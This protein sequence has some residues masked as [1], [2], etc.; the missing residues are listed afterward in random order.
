MPALSSGAASP[1]R[2]VAIGGL[3]A[4]AIDITYAAGFWY[5]RSGVPPTRIFQSVAA[6]LLG[7][8][9]AVAGGAPTAALGLALHFLIALVVSLVYFAAARR[10]AALRQRPW[11][12]GALYGVGVYG[13]MHYIVVPLSRAGGG[14]RPNL[15]WDLLSIVVHAVGIGI[16]VALAARAALRGRHD[17]PPAVGAPSAVGT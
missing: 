4:G 1:W 3:A 6:G 13:V 7:R 8:E 10:A 11:L 14:G 16:P 2:W 5:L 12:F 9:A 15:L 17:A